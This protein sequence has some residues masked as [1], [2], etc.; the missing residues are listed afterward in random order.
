LAAFLKQRDL[1]DLLRRLVDR[2]QSGE[3]S[4]NAYSTYAL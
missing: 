4:L 1:V 3:L 2:R